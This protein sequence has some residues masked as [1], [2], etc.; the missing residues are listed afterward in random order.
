MSGSG[1]RKLFHRPEPAKRESQFGGEECRPLCRVW[2]S[3]AC[4]P[5]AVGGVGVA[6]VKGAAAERM[7]V[8][9][10]R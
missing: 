9:K 5:L 3:A 1:V 7:S 6:V 2:R 8:V 10:G 4:G